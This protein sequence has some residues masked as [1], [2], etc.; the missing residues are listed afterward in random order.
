VETGVHQLAHR[1]GVAVRQD[2]LRAVRRIGDGFEAI[3]DGANGFVPGDPLEPAL[4]LPAGALHRVEQPVAVVYAIEVVGDLL[5]EESSSEG[6]IG[7]ATKL[8]RPAVLDGDDQPAGVRAVV[9]ADGADGS[10]GKVHVFA[11]YRRVSCAPCVWSCGPTCF[12][13]LS[14]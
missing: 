2:R 8:D 1:P 5:A 3:G 11:S 9:R 10:Q 4:A 13:N 14:I 6:V 12:S 7:V